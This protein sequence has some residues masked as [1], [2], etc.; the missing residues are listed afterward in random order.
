MTLEQRVQR[1]ERMLVM[2]AKAGH[3]ARLEWRVRSREQ[4]E[5]INIIINAHMEASEIIKGLALGQSRL[6]AGQ[7]RLG[8]GQTTLDKKMAE[9]AESQK[10]TNEALQ[11][12]LN[13][14]RK[15]GKDQSSN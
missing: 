4:D 7:A 13:T 1:A 2:M 3:R 14:Q 12:F 9:L 6:D 5:K 8:A 11:A 15:G 10:L